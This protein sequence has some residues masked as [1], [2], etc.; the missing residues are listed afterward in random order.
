MKLSQLFSGQVRTDNTAS[1]T[2]QPT[3]AQ[4]EQVNRQLRSLVPGQTIS[5]EIVSRNGG[6]VQIRLTED[7]LLNARVDRNMNI[8]IGKT[9][10]FEVKS[11]GNSLTLSP[12]FTN[13]ATDMNVLKALDMAG[14]PVNQSS[15]QMTQQLMAA[16]MSVNKNTLQ[17]IFRELN[18]YPQSAISDIIDLHK[19]GLPVNESNVN[20][21][22]AYRNLNHQLTGGMD[23]ILEAL[24]E[25]FEEMAAKGDTGGAV[26][27][28]GEVLRLFQEG[29]DGEL[30]M[31]GGT[32]AESGTAAGGAVP[33]DSAVLPDGAGRN[34]VGDAKSAQTEQ[35]EFGQRAEM[36]FKTI[37]DGSM[38]ELLSMGKGPSMK[39]GL[40]M[41]EGLSMKEGLSAEEGISREMMQLTEAGKSTPAEGGVLSGEGTAILSP[42][43]SAEM[44]NS[45]ALRSAVADEALKLLDGLRLSPEEESAVR[46]QIMQFSQGEADT[47]Q[48]FSALATLAEGARF[49][50]D[51]M[52]TLAKM[53]S[54]TK[55]RHLLSEHIKN[56]WMLRPEDVASPEKVEELYR[57]LDRQLRGLTDILEHA[58]QSGSA[59]YKA[60]TSMSQ[61]IDFLQQINQMYAYVQLPLKLQQREA[62]GELYVYTNRKKLTRN[63]GNVSAL[64]HLD[65][66]YLGPVDVY[67]SM[68]NTKVSTKFYLRD[69]EMIDFIGVHMDILT[70]R[71]KERGY[72]CSCSMVRRDAPAGEATKG[73]LEP[74][75]RQE[76]GIMLS[77]YSFDVRT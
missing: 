71:L 49:S 51:S 4:L 1:A 9:M 41:G 53:F 36:A 77:H 72:E 73:G 56:N 40:S 57:R 42:E 58:G 18:T 38:E 25:A 3:P 68:K 12:L 20:Q 43:Q 31:K 34:S 8:E 50:Q 22:T 19:L 23:T 66:E 17:Q 48:F 27:L 7:V 2:S 75:L 11:N 46:T 55:F 54:G 60:A 24:P 47:Q 64:L 74:V 15:V 32:F 13:V 76:K 21:M 30:S 61:N 37:A 65:M 28:Y 33:A 16:G 14:L 69:D 5:G 44:E 10:T 39:E 67:V 59:A 26:K 63:D 62:H 70:R 45:R 35:G 29:M 52:H 6:E